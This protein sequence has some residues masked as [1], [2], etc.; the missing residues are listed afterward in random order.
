MTNYLAIFEQASI[1]LSTE[2]FYVKILKGE[3]VTAA[4][5]DRIEKKIGKIINP[6]L[7]FF[8]LELGDRF[9][10]CIHDIEGNEVPSWDPIGIED[11]A[12]HNQGFGEMICEEISGNS[13]LMVKNEADSRKSWMP[14]YG[15]SGG[16]DILCLDKNGYVRFYESLT[17]QHLP[18]TWSAFV[19]TSFHDFVTKWGER[20]FIA[21]M[22]DWAACCS[23]LVGEFDWNHDLFQ[24]S[25]I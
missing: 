24:P 2:G 19:A 21:P 16:G 22:G 1:N 14:F 15:F 6:E 3:P 5:I 7:K 12:T 17:W 20:S 25:I 18:S 10:F 9:Q 11:L 23:D 8:L 4:E 13:N